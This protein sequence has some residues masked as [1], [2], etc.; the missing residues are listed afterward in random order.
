M[1]S[2]C[3]LAAFASIALA[4]VAQQASAP[5]PPAAAGYQIKGTVVDAAGGAPLPGT[6][7]SVRQVAPGAGNAQNAATVNAARTMRAEEAGGVV[8]TGRPRGKYAISA[9]RRG[10]PPQLLDQHEN[11]S[12]AAVVGPEAES[13][14]I[15]FRLRPEA[16]I[17]GRVVDENNEPVRN[18][19]V[20]LFRRLQ[21]G[22]RQMV[23]PGRQTQSSDEGSYRFSH[24]AAGTYLVAVSAQPW[25]AQHLVSQFG[26]ANPGAPATDHPDPL[27]VAYPLTFYPSATDPDGATS[28]VLHPGDRALADLG[29]SPV[30]ALHLRLMTGDPERSS[31]VAARLVRS[32]PDG[33]SVPV[34]AQT[35]YT[36][37]GV[38]ELTG[39]PPGHYELAV[40]SP[41]GKGEGAS[42]RELDLANDASMELKDASSGVALS[43]VVQFEGAASGP[44][45]PVIQMRNVASG[46]VYAAPTSETGEFGISSSMPA[47]TYEIQ[48]LAMPGLFIRSIAASGAKVIG[49]SLQIAGSNPVRLT[50]AMTAGTGRVDG[51]ALRDGKPA[52]GAMIV[53]VPQDPLHDEPLFRRDQSDSDGSFT[54]PAVVPGKYTVL[55][56][57]NAWD[58]DWSN[59]AVLRRYLST[60][61]SLQVEPRGRYKV[62]LA[63]Q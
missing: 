22:G 30:P 46:R 9:Q 58:L 14:N 28:I 23:R 35:T 49:R 20:T 24:L 1:R 39:V 45:R 54:L 13:D 55:A 37:Q 19:Q 10:Y 56:I 53:L 11:F 50:I 59:P 32:W 8:I 3:R 61:E 63:V 25:Y 2:V 62:K 38:I 44:R 16:S 52:A 60:G 7:V 48:A 5:P 51:V 34:P 31:R 33:L 17:S 15:V 42:S 57:E 4:V 26:P 43:G 36:G 41:N 29:L 40:Q 12:T 47:G 21:Q 18:A 27:D 6:R